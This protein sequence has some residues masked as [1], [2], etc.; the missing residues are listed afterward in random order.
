MNKVRTDKQEQLWLDWQHNKTPENMG[1]LIDAFQPMIRSHISGLHNRTLPPSALEAEAAL[2][3]R[4]AFETYNPRRGAALSTHVGNRLQKVN[5]FVYDHQSVGRVPEGQVLRAAQ[6]R[7]AQD[8]LLEQKGRDATT[9]ELAKTLGWSHGMVARTRRGLE[10]EVAM[11]THPIFE[12]LNPEVAN[13]FDTQ[14][15]LKYV[16]TD[17]TPQERLVFE[18]TFGYG[19]RR[20]L[21]TNR[22]I[23][24]KT[25][26]SES[27]V[28]AIKASIDRQIAAFQRP[29]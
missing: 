10:G 3:A 13:R 6:Y 21:A 8:R 27:K 23:A 4:Q 26:F 15:V 25:R 7:A 9:E 14:V 16:Y 20:P 1:R 12:E 18:H 29:S 17:L 11:S 2:Q 5:R 19:G 24:Q 22:D 28:R